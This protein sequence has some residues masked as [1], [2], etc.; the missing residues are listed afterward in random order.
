V[1][2]VAPLSS[3]SE[4]SP[5]VD[6]ALP[7]MVTI[8]SNTVV[9]WHERLAHVA[10]D[11]VVCMCRSGAVTGMRLRKKDVQTAGLCAC[12]VQAK[13]AQPP[14]P[15]ASQRVVVNRGDRVS[16]D[17]LD[18]GETSPAG[19]RYLVV[20]LDEATYYG[21]GYTMAARSEIF[22]HWLTYYNGCKSRDIVVRCLRAD[23]EYDTN[24]FAAFCDANGVHREYTCAKTPQQNGRSERFNRTC[25]EMTRAL[26]IHAG[27]PSLMWPLAASVAVYTINRV[28]HHC[29]AE[30]TTPFELW[31]NLKPDVSHMRVFGTI[32]YQLVNTL[33]RP[34]PPK[35]QAKADL[36][37]FVGYSEA[38]KGYKL[39]DPVTLKIKYSRAVAFDENLRV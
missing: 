5:L 29:I 20:F 35:L 39:L 8:P 18:F 24:K 26:L 3:G 15:Q 19:K 2:S 10:V 30:G 37:I 11:T 1:A 36:R 33:R 38:R 31:F 34:K 25:G 28:P 4:G 23:N 7:A 32:C 16:S 22:D 14:F 27:L 13:L 6:Y 12:C 21:V 17:I 9:N